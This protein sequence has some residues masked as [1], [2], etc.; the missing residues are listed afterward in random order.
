[1]SKV[2]L[3]Y[4]FNK[5]GFQ[6]AFTNAKI[7]AFAEKSMGEAKNISLKEIARLKKRAT[8][9]GLFNSKS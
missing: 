5:A 1:M 9:Y 4:P 6:S 2:R 7:R 8:A 3:N